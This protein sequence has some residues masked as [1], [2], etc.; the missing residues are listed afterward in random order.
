MSYSLRPY[1]VAAIE[2]VTQLYLTGLRRLL[3]DL[4]TGGGKTV[5]ATEGLIKP[6]V[7]IGQRVL[8][9][10][11]R[12]ELIMQ[13][14]DKLGMPEHVGIIK[15]GFDPKPEV[16]VQI[17]SIQTLARRTPPPADLVIWDEAHHCSA[18]NYERIQALYPLARH[19]GLSATPYR[20]DGKGLGR[21]FDS[22]VK[23]ATIAQLIELKFLVKSRTFALPP[24]DLKGIRTIAGDYN[25]DQL[26]ERMNK[27]RIGIRVVE[28]Y[29][30]YAA[31][32]S[33]LCFAVNVAHS[34]QLTQQ[35]I[36]AGIIAEHIDGT[37]PTL[38]RRAI[39]TR[40][41]SGETKVVCNCAVLTEGFDCPRVSCIILV[42]PTKSR[43]LW[44]QCVG[45]GL[46]P[47]EDKV[48]CQ[49]HDHAGCHDRFGHVEA[50]EVTSL[51][52]GV[53]PSSAKPAPYK[54]C[55]NC[56]AILPGSPEVCSECGFVFIRVVK[57]PKKVDQE[58][59]EV[60]DKPLLLEDI[61]VT[62]QDALFD[63][64]EEAYYRYLLGQ[65]AEKNYKP[66]WIHHRLS[67]KFPN[68]TKRFW[69]IEREL[70][71]LINLKTIRQSHGV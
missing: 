46:R 65:A 4:P 41:A 71:R 20:L 70:S 32:R 63:Q 33:A 10:A 23:V 16:L 27:S 29:Q 55:S 1:Q 2:R 6:A 64:S 38:E 42:R 28:T 67:A 62:P 15:Y 36:D 9:I 31:G 44:R 7:A 53:K 43:C 68:Q 25:Q 51:D 47:Y 66:G 5:I 57:E 34:Q 48:D 17:A 21:C 18:A 24:P 19:A 3:L 11:H 49:I 39:L 8:F 54:Q 58:L 50:E 59:V 69:M 52:D 30:R 60:V 37:T 12:E 35:F 13:C 56:F 14:A 45:R 61:I 40:L 26:A 22:L